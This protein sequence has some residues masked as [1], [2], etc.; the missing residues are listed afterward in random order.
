M[1]WTER[2]QQAI[3]YRENKD[4]LVAA[5]AGS[6]KT[7]VMVERVIQL[8]LEGKA[9]IDEILA[10]TFTKAAASGMKE[11]IVAR[12][13]A[14]IGEDVAKG[15]G[16]SAARLSNQLSLVQEADISTFDSFA[17]KVVREN[18]QA[19]DVDPGAGVCDDAKSAIMREKALD[20]LLENRLAEA[21][22]DFIAFM[23]SYSSVKSLESVKES[24]MPLRRA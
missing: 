14:R 20:E 2:Q 1:G 16:E 4:L 21:T 12:L 24:I 23:D 19:I 18:F 10:V 6:G 11:K 7:S 15:D 3:D 13:R 5:A 9:G 22:P 8:I 17:Q